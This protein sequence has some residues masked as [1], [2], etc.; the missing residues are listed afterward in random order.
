[1]ACKTRTP[2]NYF[3]RPV[4]RE[5]ITL[6]DVGK[7]ACNGRVYDIPIGLTI[8]RD[9]MTYDDAYDYFEDKEYRLFQC[10]RFK[11]CR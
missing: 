3:N 7:M 1:M 9:Q 2:E 8:P 5:C 4:L 10:L 6:A 11:R